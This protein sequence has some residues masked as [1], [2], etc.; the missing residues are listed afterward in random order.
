MSRVFQDERVSN[1]KLSK[2]NTRGSASWPSLRV[3]ML[4]VSI[5]FLVALGGGLGL[6]RTKLVES[7]AGVPGPRGTQMMVVSPLA[8]ESS[9]SRSFSAARQLAEAGDKAGA[10]RLLEGIP[11]EDPAFPVAERLRAEI[12][13]T[14][15]RR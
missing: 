10:L 13:A 8:R 2:P 1:E 9:G 7:L 3:G 15:G 4:V 6:G 12:A 5:L 11:R 14:R